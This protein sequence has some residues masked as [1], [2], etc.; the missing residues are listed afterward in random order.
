M[1]SLFKLSQRNRDL[2]SNYLSTAVNREAIFT[3][4]VGYAMASTMPLPPQ[5][6]ND[7]RDYYAYN[8]KK[9]NED[10]LAAFNELVPFD[11]M[12]AR[13]HTLAFYKLRY[14]TTFSKVVPLSMNPETSLED[15]FGISGALSK[16][17]IDT[18]KKNA[19]RLAVLIG[20]IRELLA[21]INACQTA[22]EVEAQ[23]KKEGDGSYVAA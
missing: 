7:L 11:T 19:P 1:Y 14:N 16:G 17:A 21:E 8:G 10:L 5:A 12:A 6:V 22:R 20:R 13:E 4:A 15:F 3:L 2:I 9:D 18:I 23:Y